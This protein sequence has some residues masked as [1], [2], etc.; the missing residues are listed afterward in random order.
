METRPEDLLQDVQADGTVAV[1]KEGTGSD[2]SQPRA[3]PTHLCRV[4]AQTHTCVDSGHHTGTDF[5]R[6]QGFLPAI[7]KDALPAHR[8]WAW[9]WPA[10]LGG[11]TDRQE[12]R[13]SSP[14]KLS[15][16]AHSKPMQRKYRGQNPKMCV[17]SEKARVHSK[18][19]AIQEEINSAEDKGP[20]QHITGCPRCP[21][22]A[23]LVRARQGLCA[24]PAFTA[25]EAQWGTRR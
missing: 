24:P 20:E 5:A 21:A 14:R 4:Q 19:E 2:P 15:A 13:T 17:P 22:G 25:S 9:S 23:E 11:Q 7:L 10:A 6:K 18:V 16:L 12:A 8:G 1:E 3:R